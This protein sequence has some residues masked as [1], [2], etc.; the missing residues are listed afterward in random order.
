MVRRARRTRYRR[1]A[2]RGVCGFVT[3][4][5]SVGL[6]V[7]TSTPAAAVPA[8]VT[9]YVSP[10]GTATTG[11]TDS[12]TE[13]CTSIQDGIDAAET[14]G[15][16]NVT[17][18]VAAATYDE[19]D[20]IDVPSGDTLTLQGAGAPSTTVVGGGKSAVFGITA[21]TVT[22]DGLTITG[23]NASNG[24]GVRNASGTLNLHGD[25][26]YA[27]S[28][29]GKGGGVFSDGTATLI[30]DTLLDNSS[31]DGGGGIYSH[32]SA[33]LIDDTLLDNVS[34]DNEG[35]GVFSH[36]TA[37]LTDDT[38]AGG[39]EFGGGVDNGPGTATISNSIL[40]VAPCS[41]SISDGGYNVESD[42]SCGF[43][44]TDLVNNPYINLGETDANGSSG[45]QTAAIGPNSSAFEE[46]PSANCK[47]STDERGVPRPG[48]SEENCDAGAFEA[49]YSSTPVTLSVDGADG[50]STT[51]CTNSGTG[52]CLTVQEGV[53]AAELYTDTIL[54]VG[55][56]SGTYDENDTLEVP[57]GDI[58]TL[59]GAGVSTT[60]VDGG[61]AASVF[62]ISAGT[63]TLDGFTITDG[64]AQYGG[65][66]SNQGT[67]TLTDDS[68]SDS[69]TPDGGEGGGVYNGGTATLSDDTLSGDQ[70]PEGDGG[71]VFSTGSLTLTDDTLS[72][73]SADSGGQG[74]GV[75]A[76]LFPAGGSATLSDDTF[77]G[78]SAY[79]GGGVALGGSTVTDDT[80][81][82]DTVQY[83]GGGAYNV[84]GGAFTSDTFSGDTAGYGGGGAY[85]YGAIDT[86]GFEDTWTDDT[87]GNDSAPNGGGIYAIDSYDAIANSIIDEAPCGGN[88]TFSDGGY[89]VESDDSCGFGSTDVVNSSNINLATSLASNGS[90]GPE[91]LAITSTSSAFEEVPQADCAVT[92][93]ERGDPRPG[94]AGKNC[95]AGA[96]EVQGH[97]ESTTTK[98]SES[99]PSI[100]YGAEGSE[101]FTV[102]VTGHSGDGAPEG[103]VAVSD[104]ST[105]LCSAALTETSSDQAAATCWPTALEVPAG[106]YS[107]VLASYS[108]ATVSS[109]STNDAY[110]SSRSTPAKSFAVAKDTTTTEV[111]ENPTTV[112]RGHESASIFSVVVTTTNGESV[113]DGENVTVDVGT[114][115]CTVALIDGVGTCTIEPT[116]LKLGTY[117]V[118][119]TY[120]G[121]ANLSSSTGMSSAKLTVNKS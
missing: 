56:A 95:D 59:Q 113:P 11:C 17:I 15:D 60:T 66:I 16:T 10:S 2:A 36:G 120:G 97:K 47:V 87:F 52:A 35:G 24:G 32:G 90:S 101:T 61:G 88:G 6:V 51:G 82:G 121:D 5:A 40:D 1:L 108:P 112:T 78:D 43:G 38:L 111:S 37:T 45:P 85:S 116:A 14:Y 70:A 3:A 104:A 46:V 64:S 96:F 57:S 9:L 8:A 13:A 12:G 53:N 99:V 65:G 76:G 34:Y 86:A 100:T 30:D 80:F 92:T 20:T 39:G 25:T 75:N 81:S 29:N 94:F 49:V 71:G 117:S 118:S 98:L 79:Q 110:A 62:S 115:T 84:G 103:T 77:S 41:G 72:N 93:D 102:T 7:A 4:F 42:D 107:A 105:Q 48:V 44:S 33:T 89:N 74:G 19:S 54:T 28:S 31:N 23:G 67:L 50:T 63:V 114:T 55:V 26:L 69:S 91:T 58:L 21:G 22:I 27:N 109:S 83:E 68:V 106:S 119:A 73:D 18:D